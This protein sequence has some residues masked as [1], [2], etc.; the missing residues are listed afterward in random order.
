[1]KRSTA[2]HYMSQYILLRDAIKLGQRRPGIQD[3]SF[4]CIE[5]C[6]CGKMMNRFAKNS[7]AGHYVPKG[8][9]GSSGVYFDE[10]NVHAQ[11]HNC[12]KWEEGNTIEYTPFMV[13]TY[14]QEIIDELRLKHK[15]PRPHS[16]D[17][18]GIMYREMY[19]ELKKEH[20]L[21]R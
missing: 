10:R 13:K 20:G 19:K 2:N 15:L 6:T 3:S 16:I 1:M 9:G 8:M 12:N 14:G 7:H 18:Y 11:C 21:S 17:E 5:C 4:D